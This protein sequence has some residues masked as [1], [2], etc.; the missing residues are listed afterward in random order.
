[1]FRGISSLVPHG[2]VSWGFSVLV[3]LNFRGWGLRGMS[4]L[5]KTPVFFDTSVLLW[6]YTFSEYSPSG[7]SRLLKLR[8]NIVIIGQSKFSLVR[9]F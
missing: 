2:I 5:G 8:V 4:L 3:F 1:M 6:F 7:V 9:A